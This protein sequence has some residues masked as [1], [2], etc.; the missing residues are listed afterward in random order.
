MKKIILFAFFG[1]FILGASAQDYKNAI[2]VRGGGPTGITF[3]HF[4]GGNAALEFILAPRHHGFEA[5][6]LYELHANAFSVPRLNWY[7]GVGG[8]VGF[9]DGSRYG[10]FDR[11]DNFMALGVDGIVGL[12]YNIPAIP[13][14]ISVDFKPALN[15]VGYV[16]LWFDGA[17]SV[18]YYW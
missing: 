13:I 10:K 11:R 8:H 14:N 1:L 16:G 2:G 4:T 9:Y 18:R 5:V 6:G 3:K 15:L 17:F 12:E 7:Y